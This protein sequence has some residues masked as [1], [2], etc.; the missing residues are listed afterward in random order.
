MFSSH[1]PPPTPQPGRLGKYELRAELGRGGMGIVYRGYDTVLQR[2]VAIKVLAPELSSDAHFVRRFHAEAT[3]AAN[4]R[5]PHIVAIYDVGQAG[6]VHFIVTEL[7]TGTPLHRWVQQRGPLTPAQ[8]NAVLR[9]VASALDYAHGRG[10][11]HC[12]VKPANIMVDAAGH[13]TLLDFGLARARE[14]SGQSGELSAGTLEYMAPEQVL[15]QPLDARADVYALAATLYYLLTG[16]AP[17]ERAAP[18][19]VA[20][21]Q[22]HEPPPAV[23]KLRPDL[24]KP[25]EA[26][27]LKGLAKAP[28]ERY[29]SAGTLAAD[30]ATAVTGKTSPGLKRTPTP[31][32]A[33]RRPSPTPSATPPPRPAPRP[34]PLIAALIV[35]LIALAAGLAWWAL[36]PSPAGA[37]T[38]TAVVVA[39]PD[40]PTPTALPPTATRAATA[41]VIALPSPATP[42]PRPTATLA[43]TRAAA[44]VTATIAPTSAQ[45]LRATPASPATVSTARLLEPADGATASGDVVFAWEGALGPGQAYEVRLWREGSAEHPGAAELVAQPASGRAQQ[46]IDLRLTPAVLQGGNGVYWWTVAVVNADPYQRIGAEAPPRRLNYSGGEPAPPA[47]TGAAPPAASDSDLALSLVLAVGGVMLVSGVTRREREQLR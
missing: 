1:P 18:A 16:Q 22:V 35:L 24:P 26:A 9:Q 47:S 38:P 11:V 5:H 3:A 8:A 14:T 12:D 30:F 45:P 10:M 43:S 19:A 2:P 40:T 23:R 36:S 37:P 41:A 42:T 39:L 25:V 6:D 33:A 17:F 28:A 32:S 21:A 46:R 15:G 20:Y 29:P 4:L 7:L 31:D 44:A 13:A 27:L 34:A